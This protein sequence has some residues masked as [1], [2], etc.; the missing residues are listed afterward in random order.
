MRI[1]PP[2]HSRNWLTFGLMSTAVISVL[3]MLSRF[4]I[5]GQDFDV[6]IALRLI[7]LSF[8]LSVVYSLMGWFGATRMWACSNAGLLLGLV[9]MVYYSGGTTGWEELIGILV[10]MQL[11]VAGIAL[12]IV[13]EVVRFIYLKI[14]K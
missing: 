11:I 13:V 2:P 4:L 7:L 14:K 8:I 3:I 6:I 1:I 9:L 10:F 12:G 5:I